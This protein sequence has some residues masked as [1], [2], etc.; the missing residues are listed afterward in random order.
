MVPYNQGSGCLGDPYMMHE[1]LAFISWDGHVVDCA[2][3]SWGADCTCGE[4]ERQE[5]Q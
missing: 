4:L 2:A 5:R 1:V 3:A